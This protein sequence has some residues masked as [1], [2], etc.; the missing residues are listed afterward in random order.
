LVK[1]ASPV[2]AAFFDTK[3][4][5]LDY[6][7]GYGIFVRMMRD[8][9]FDFYWLDEYCENLVARG[10]ELNS[11]TKKTE[12]VTSFETFEHFTDP[13]AEI[14]KMLKF[15][16]NILFTTEI[17]EDHSFPDP[18]KWWYYSFPSGQHIGFYTK[19]SFEIIAKKYSLNFYSNG[20]LHLFTKKD[21]NIA[22]NSYFLNSFYKLKTKLKRK[23]LANPID[24]A[25]FYSK[26]RPKFVD[27]LIKSKTKSDHDLL[28]NNN[29]ISH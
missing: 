14:E 21:L 13:L 1:K 18:E 2:I 27:K 25:I 22:A 20:F 17:V 8:V 12:L 28:E 10:F 7:G 24:F 26:V 4:K 15:S 19:K 29:T 16:D 9:G 11:L 23:K 6:G 3:A 5:F